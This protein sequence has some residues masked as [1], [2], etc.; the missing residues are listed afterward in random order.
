MKFEA[1]TQTIRG[2]ISNT[3]KFN[4][5]SLIRLAEGGG[6]D[7]NKILR[8]LTMNSEGAIDLGRVK[9][10]SD[11]GV[12]NTRV[13]KGSNDKDMVEFTI[14]LTGTSFK[15]SK[16]KTPEIQTAQTYINRQNEKKTVV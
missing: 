16:L 3:N 7:T 12:L 8:K 5:S 10:L 13:I 15:F 14:D 9:N 6:F 2:T 11:S 1:D 4:L